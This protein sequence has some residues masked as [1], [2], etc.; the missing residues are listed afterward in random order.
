MLCIATASLSISLAGFL[1]FTF[2]FLLVEVAASSASYT[3][4]SLGLARTGVRS[5][6]GFYELLFEVGS[7]DADLGSNVRSISAVSSTKFILPA[8]R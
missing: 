5:S 3:V 7:R 2:D 1:I 4:G 8:V 6:G